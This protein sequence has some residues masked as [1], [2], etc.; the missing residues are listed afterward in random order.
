MSANRRSKWKMLR[1]FSLASC[2]SS[3]M[4]VGATRAMSM[5]SS[6]VARNHSSLSSEH[7]NL[8]ALIS[9][10]CQPYMTKD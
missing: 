8:S 2:S 5:D 9:T 1:K 6:R 3:S 10:S 4:V 7:E